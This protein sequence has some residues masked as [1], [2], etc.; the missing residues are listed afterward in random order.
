MKQKAAKY[1]PDGDDTSDRAGDPIENFCHQ[2]KPITFLINRFSL[3]R[4]KM[5]SITYGR[6]A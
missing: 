4:L 1:T 5:E 2:I 3:P 6:R